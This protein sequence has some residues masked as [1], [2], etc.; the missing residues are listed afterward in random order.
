[1]PGACL[2]THGVIE[3]Q[4]ADAHLRVNPDRDIS[5][6]QRL[7]ELV[8]FQLTSGTGEPQHQARV[9]AGRLDKPRIVA[10]GPEGIHDM[11]RDLRQ[12]RAFPG[13]EVEVLRRAVQ[14]LMR[15]E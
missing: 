1:M 15:P 8:Y 7:L 13:G 3:R 12:R 14:D 2:Q 10:R 6:S 9:T 5:E 11:P 4:G